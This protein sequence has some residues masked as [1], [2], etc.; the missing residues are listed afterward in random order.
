MT[1]QSKFKFLPAVIAVL[2]A[3]CALARF[4]LYRLAVDHKGLLISGHPLAIAGWILA[5]AAAALTVLAVWKCRGSDR[6]EDN[7]ESSVWAAIGCFALAG[8]IALAVLTG[9]GASGTMAQITMVA[10]LLAVPALAA[11][12]LHRFQGRKPFFLLYG[13]PCLYLALYALGHYQVWSSQPQLQ[14][15][16]W[17]MAGSVSLTLFSYYKTAFC[18][19]LGNR[20][21][22]LATGLLAG[23][24]C[25][26][27]VGS[28]DFL[29][30][31]GG[32]VWALTD[33]CVMMSAAS[34]KED[35][36]ETA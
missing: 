24:F 35:S 1:N 27:A 16:F 32:A 17:V 15:W 8:G 12:G 5:A 14:D 20:K 2:G 3:V 4:G 10:G 9:F 11:A 7:F 33:L 18:V 36:D 13:I 22:Q 21:L 30:Y 6:Y 26:S 34:E 19:E 25:L 31:L 29:L 28:G 23:F